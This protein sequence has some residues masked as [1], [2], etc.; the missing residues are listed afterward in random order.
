VDAIQ[1]KI[2]NPSSQSRKNAQDSM[3]LPGMPQG[4]TLV[5]DGRAPSVV[6]DSK[7]V[8]LLWHFPAAMSSEDSQWVRVFI[9]PVCPIC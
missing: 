1:E 7:G 5:S 8:P 4:V 9:Y 2:K 6:T 3:H